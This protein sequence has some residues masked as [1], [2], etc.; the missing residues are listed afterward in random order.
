MSCTAKHGIKLRILTVL[1]FPK[2][3]GWILNAITC[4]FI[5]ARGRGGRD[6]HT[7]E[8]TATEEEVM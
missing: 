8:R 5:R 7:V 2:L 4:V 6:R 3:D 1:A